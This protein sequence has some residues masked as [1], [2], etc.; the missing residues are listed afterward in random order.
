MRVCVCVCAAIIKRVLLVVLA[1][2]A[3]GTALFYI[4]LEYLFPK[5]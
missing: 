3:L 4:G 2:V 5:Y 1:A